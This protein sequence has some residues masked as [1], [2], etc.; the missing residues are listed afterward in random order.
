MA[1]PTLAKRPVREREIK[2]KVRQLLVSHGRGV[3]FHFPVLLGYG[4]MTLD[5][6]G[7]AYGKFFA[8]ETKA[9]ASRKPTD[10]QVATAQRMADAGGKVFLVYDDATLTNFSQWL[11]QWR[12]E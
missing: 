9:S 12:S 3:Y 10:R 6:I 2:K 7:C 4:E 1:T 11:E 5:I 8:V